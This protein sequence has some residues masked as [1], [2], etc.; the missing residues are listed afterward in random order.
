M[1]VSPAAIGQDQ[2]SAAALRWQILGAAVLLAV[3]AWVFWAFLHR[4]WRFA[5]THQADWGH[6]LVIPFICA[7]F[8][9]LNR[10]KLLVRPFRPAWSGLVPMLLGVAW[11]TTCAIG[12]RP[13]FHHNL[14]G[15]GVWLAFFGLVLLIFGYRAMKYLWFPLLYLLVFGQTISNKFMEI[16]TYK[17][18]DITARG[19]HLVLVLL[20]MD[21]DRAGNTLT[22][23]QDGE[24][25]PLNIAEACSGMR[26]L[27][28]FL[29]LGVFMAYTG[30]DRSWQRTALVILAFPTAVFVN[31][32]RVVTLALLSKVDTDFAAGE[33]HSFVGLVWLVPALLI[34]L[35]LMWIIRNS[36][37]EEARPGRT[38][39]A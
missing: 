4:Q 13:L 23:F 34:Y 30:L 31:I 37:I 2:S 29:A 24:P 16:V 1:S 6:T 39:T 28:A 35:G 36:V 19:S 17:L 9:Y 15:A 18:Q 5:I 20:G 12:P 27:M 26:M 38:G 21:V 8:V 3:F 25:M 7:Y 33:F 14:Q 32:L 22:V 11:Y 10:A